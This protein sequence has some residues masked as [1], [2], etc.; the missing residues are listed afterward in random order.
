MQV[1]EENSG[2]DRRVGIIETSTELFLKNGYSGTSMSKIAAAC[3]I[4]KA[5]LYHHFAGKEELF[6]ACVTH[7]YSAALVALEEI[8]SR[9][10]PTAEDKLR[11]ALSALY[12]TIISSPVGRMSPLIAEVSRMFPTV[13]RSF[14]TEYI[15]PQQALLWRIIDQG[16]ENGTFLKVDERQI[17]HLIFGPIVMLSLSREMFASFDDLDT[18]FP[19]LQLRDGHIDAILGMMKAKSDA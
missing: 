11:A 13:A 6:V 12:E 1:T 14:H 2:A 4:T 5:S 17:F 16:V 7:G 3:G 8:A 19:V 9:S 18:H 10:G 15:E